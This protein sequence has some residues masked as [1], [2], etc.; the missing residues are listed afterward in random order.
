MNEI[1]AKKEL[2]KKV[3]KK[4]EGTKISIGGNKTFYKR[5]YNLKYSQ[6]I[7]DNVI[8]AFMDVIKDTVENGDTIKFNG[9]MVIAPKYYAKRH[10][11]NVYE[12][13]NIVV[14][15][16]YK[17]RISA[18]SKLKEAAKRLTDRE[19]AEKNSH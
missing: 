8:S 18:G 15:E 12:K 6:E 13:K 10:A 4:L 16:Q 14:P 3:V 2:V 17:V 11:R 7:T 19:L 9:Y 1:I 5:L